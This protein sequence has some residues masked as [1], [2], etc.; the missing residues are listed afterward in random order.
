[1]ARKV[2]AAEGRT[3]KIYDN[4]GTLVG[5]GASPIKL[6]G[7]KP[8]S[9]YNY[10]CTAVENGVESEKVAIPTIK[11]KAA[12]VAVTGVDLKPDTA[13]VAVGAT[14]QLTANVQPA[15]ATNKAVSYKS[16]DTTK[17]T[18]DAKG[19]VTGVAAGTADITVTT[20]DGN[21]TDKTTITVTA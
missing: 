2:K 3:F 5:E 10:M 8:S 16:S 6:T 19:V 15:N 1:M 7:L 4:G 18:V 11:T 9:T 12:N 14:T 21:K 13:S 20:T 17:A